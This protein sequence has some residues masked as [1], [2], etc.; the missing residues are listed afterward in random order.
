MEKNTPPIR[1]LSPGR[2]YRNEADFL[3]NH[4]IFHQVE[5]LYID[6]NVSFKFKT[7]STLF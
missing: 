5:G 1:T 6:E 2:V 7:N 3:K 4:C